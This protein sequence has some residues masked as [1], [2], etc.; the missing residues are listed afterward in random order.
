MKSL[1]TALHCHTHYSILDGFSTPKEN[2]QRC[3]DLGINTY[4]I[5]EHGN[6]YSWIYFAKL[7]K[8][9]FPDIKLIYG[10]EMYECDDMSVQ[11]KNNKYYHLIVMARNEEGRKALNSLTTA[12]NLEGFYFK[13]RISLDR[14]KPFGANLI[15]TSACMGGR[16]HREKDYQKCV[17]YIKEYKSTFY[18]FYLEIQPHD[19]ED[20][21]AYNLKLLQLAKDTNTDLILGVDA[22]SATKDDL[23]YQKYHV[24]TARDIETAEEIY[25]GCYIQSTED[26]YN[27]LSYLDDE[28]IDGIIGNTNNLYNDFE[29][30]KMPFQ[31]PVLPEFPLDSK[32]ETDKDLMRY[33]CEKQLKKLHLEDRQDYTERLDYEIKI[34][35]Q[36][37][38]TGYF[39]ILWDLI[40]YL[41]GIG[42]VVGL[43][44]GSAAGS[45]VCYLLGI[46]QI[47]PIK[48]DLHFERFLNPERIGMPDID[49]DLANRDVA[50]A[51]LM[52]KY[53]SDKVC[54]IINFSYITPVVA[55]KDVGKTLQIPYVESERISKFFNYD[56]FED[57]YKA[58]PS[59]KEMKDYQQWFD[60]AEH[61]TGKIRQESV[62]AG[63]VGIVRGEMC[64][65]MGLK[66]GS[67]K[68]HV[69][70]LD[71]KTVESIGIVKYDLLGLK[72]LKIISETL[73]LA[74]ID[75]Y[76][77][78]PSNET[79]ISDVKS[80]DLISSGDTNLVFQME[81][82][83][84]KELATRIVPKSVHELS[85]I[86]AL[87]RPDTMP[88]IPKYIESKNSPELITYIHEDM[89]PILE[90]TY[91]A[92]VYQEQIMRIVQKFGGRTLGQAD[93]FRK[94]IGKKDKHL[95]AQETSTLKDDIIKN[96]YDE[97]VANEVVQ[98]LVDMG[99]YCFN[100]A[101]SFSYAITALQTAYLKSHY[102]TEFFTACL[103]FADKNDIGKYLIEA[104]QHGVTVRPPSINYSQGEFSCKNNVIFFGLN[105]IHGFPVSSTDMIISEREQNGLYKDFQDFE[106]RT[107]TNLTNVIKLVK[108][109]AIPVK[110]KRRFLEEYGKQLY[111][112]GFV[113]K[114]VKTLPSILK[115]QTEWGIDTE[116]HTTK[117]ERLVA[118][119]D[120]KKQKEKLAY[121][122]KSKKQ[123]EDY[124]EKY[125]QNEEL[126]EF[127]M[128]NMF[129]THN[130]F[131]DIYQYI[132]PV[133]EVENHQYGT[134][135]GVIS[136]VQKK[137]DKRK[138]TYAYL[139]I[140]SVDGI[141]EVLVWSREYNKNINFI[142]KNQKVVIHYLKKDNSL[143]AQEFKD[144]DEWYDY[145]QNSLK[146]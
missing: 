87:Y 2:L 134:L 117:E 23:Y 47:D 34:I 124:V 43:G 113:Y 94:A 13:P 3:K 104:K 96:G 139:N 56:T 97:N 118:Y 8:E 71:K 72:T 6:Q 45:L 84:M 92:L 62:H 51:Y 57:A 105:A 5:T 58:N 121:Q 103:N 24:Q 64:D 67:K 10:N 99:G 142:N 100:S 125:L 38:F 116:L 73:R 130:I 107:Q 78:H 50:I 49:T 11:D 112:N 111:C 85:D 120:A 129:I 9:E 136:S 60:I 102:P 17:D 68:E 55:I 59:L 98:M 33:L 127:E 20:Q 42:E 53:G 16:L 44:R 141:Q 126:W 39:L 69:M 21:K 137:R 54:Q 123:Y 40:K 83:G 48:Y 122:T 31:D 91:G 46:T 12:S 89:K 106:S 88:F 66:I 25:E 109:G 140:A 15:G 4:T 30:V 82:V 70:S 86:V 146:Q 7:Q 132:R 119:N 29:D 63:G 1:K 19:T 28:I 75:P 90:N 131:K 74:N 133:K 101:H 81:S 80:F 65:Y 93:I 145:F 135:I 32:F 76:A 22:H 144:F 37:D 41:R 35:T 14:I 128:L 138:N 114:P 26:V 110:N 95:I 36:M 52:Q 79:F 115:L 18:K 108:A 77:I 27:N 143:I 61:L